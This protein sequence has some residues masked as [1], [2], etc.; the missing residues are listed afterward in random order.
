[1]GKRIKLSG[2]MREI[3]INQEQEVLKDN[4]TIKGHQGTWYVIDKAES[5]QHG[6]I[7]LLEHEQFGDETAC[8]IVDSNKKI[9]VDDVYNG[10]DD[11]FDFYK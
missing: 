4:I 7:Y 11:Y 10:L 9:L 6:T 1:M 2:I 5:K 3:P 8:L